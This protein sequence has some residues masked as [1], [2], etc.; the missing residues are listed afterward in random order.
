MF[1]KEKYRGVDYLL[2]NYSTVK[3]FNVFTG[4][5]MLLLFVEISVFPVPHMKS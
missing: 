5:A 4:F 2:F 1:S 3:F